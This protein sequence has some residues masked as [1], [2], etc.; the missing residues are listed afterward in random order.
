MVPSLLCSCCSAQPF[1]LF[2]LAAELA[3]ETKAE[4]GRQLAGL[5]LK[6]TL[7]AKVRL[8]DVASRVSVI[9]GV[10]L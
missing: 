4:N 1:L 2:A 10:S 9:M 3:N 8:S 6:N 7:T 5:Y